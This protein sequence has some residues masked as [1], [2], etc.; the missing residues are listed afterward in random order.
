[1]SIALG[2]TLTRDGRQPSELLKNHPGYRLVSF[3]AEFLR[4]LRQGLIRS[5]KSDEPAHGEVTGQKSDSIR[6]K[7]S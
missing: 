1:M 5:P 6:K 7:M 4:S 2:D 3:T